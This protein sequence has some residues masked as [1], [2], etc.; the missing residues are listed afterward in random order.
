MSAD[1]HDYCR[2]YD[3]AIRAYHPDRAPFFPNRRGQFYSASTINYWFHELLNAAGPSRRGR[4]RVAAAALRSAS[5]ATSSR[6]STGGHA[7]GKTPKRCV[8]I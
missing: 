5:R 8:P 3:A 1:L 2:R 4:P 7:P 6:T